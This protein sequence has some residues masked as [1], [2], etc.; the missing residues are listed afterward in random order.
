VK[1]LFSTA[2]E[3]RKRRRKSDVFL[4]GKTV[5][6]RS[7]NRRQTRLREGRGPACPILR[8][9]G[10]SGHAPGRAAQRVGASGRGGASGHVRPDTSDYAGSS[11]DSDQTPGA[12]HPVIW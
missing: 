7:S 9:T 12:A 11:L 2:L 1:R 10:A 8:G 4:I 6:G 3:A 5:T